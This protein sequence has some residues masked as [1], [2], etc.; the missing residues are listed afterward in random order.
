MTRLPII[1]THVHFW[2]RRNPDPGLKWVWI[3]DD[4]DHPIIGNID[5][6][7]MLSYE[8]DAYNA[9]SR[10]ADVV[11]FVHVQAAIGSED[12][13]L[14]TKWLH[15]MR[16]DAP[17]PFSIVG[18]VDLQRSRG[19]RVDGGDVAVERHHCGPGSSGQLADGSTDPRAATGDEHALA[20]IPDR[21][22]GS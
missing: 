11:G 5:A 22:P 10:F 16:Q 3:A 1:D 9:E 14:E 17:L 20:G 12:P 13:V 15:R 18:D 21:S 19:T 4:V 8:V 6:I 7:K 2:N